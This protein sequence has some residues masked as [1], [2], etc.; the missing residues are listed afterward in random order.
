M[1]KNLLMIGD[2]FP[3][4]KDT[5]SKNFVIHQTKADEIDELGEDVLASI[6]CLATMG[7]A[8]AEL[9]DK[10]PNLE[11]ISSFGVGYDGVA[12]DH[13]ARKGIM[14][15]H[16]PDVLNDEVANTVIALILAT[17]RRIVAYDKYVRE[18]HWLTK[19]DAPLTHGIAG[20]TV[21]IVGLGRIGEAVAEKLSVF[22]CSVAYHTR[23]KKPDISYPYFEKLVD[24]ASSSDILVVITPGG[25]ATEK[26]ISSE[27]I[28]ALGPNGTLINVAR[29]TVVDEQAMISALQNGRLGA[30]GLDVF[31]KEPN[32]PEAL[33]SMENVVLAP[34][35]GSAT[36][37]TRQAMADR[38]VDN[39]NA[40][41][42]A[43]API[44]L[45]PECD[46]LRPK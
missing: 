25:P 33:F 11:L 9:I 46:G 2:F 6:K 24:L 29:G 20:K 38:V 22:N 7:Y 43:G 13:A 17:T 34:H 19:G 27:V 16:T 40:F 15:G 37:E 14:V 1:T 39:I 32:V 36:F 5:L 3:A 35:I 10:L 21:G 28:D 41:Y 45:V 26:L 4:M 44:N 12:A 31:E 30:A 42:K 8:P 23:N 18:G